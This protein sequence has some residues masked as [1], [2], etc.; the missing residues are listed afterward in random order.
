MEI[1]S[2]VSSCVFEHVSHRVLLERVSLKREVVSTS[3]DG[4]FGALDIL[5]PA[6]GQR[7]E[8]QDGVDLFK[9]NDF[10]CFQRSLSCF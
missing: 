5:I 9:L 4:T 7:V 3:S 2:R 1:T 6:A 10:S 8:N